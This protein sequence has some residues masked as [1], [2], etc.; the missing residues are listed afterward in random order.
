M[1]SGPSL[2]FIILN[3]STPDADIDDRTIWRCSAGHD[4]IVIG[5]LFSGRATKPAELKTATAPVGSDND[6]ALVEIIAR[7]PVVIWHGDTQIM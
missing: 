7:A 1:D 4:G 2:A 5:N 6:T 3:P